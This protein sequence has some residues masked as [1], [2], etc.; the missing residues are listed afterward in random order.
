MSYFKAKKTELQA[1]ILLETVRKKKEK[2]RKIIENLRKL[3]LNKKAVRIEDCGT[4][5]YISEI[6]NAAKITN[7]NFC[8]ERLCRVCAWR[9]QAKFV[10]QTNEVLN[11]V[12]YLGLRYIFITLTVPNVKGTEAPQTISKMM[13]AWNKISRQKLFK[14]AAVGYIR[15]LEMTYNP[16]RGDY[17]PHIHALVAVRNTYFQYAEY[18]TADQ[19]RQSWA[20]AYGVTVDHAANIPNIDIKA[21]SLE[22]ER[23][24]MLEVLKYSLKWADTEMTPEV[25]S[26][27]ISALTGRRLIS[28]GGILKEMRAALKQSDFD[29]PTTPEK[30]TFEDIEK[31]YPTVL[32]KLTERGFIEWQH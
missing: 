16:E 22:Q 8:R 28:F 9:R 11:S 7:A 15:S 30:E 32:F 2:N 6:D 19:L 23:K 13:K 31:K 1:Q 27:F 21:V 24:S 18:I 26:T 10:A 5:V 29:D 3:K 20:D 17:H 12:A 14:N 4:F 25:V